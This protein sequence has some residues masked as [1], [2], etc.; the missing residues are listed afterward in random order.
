MYHS[1]YP[2][3][4]RSC[5]FHLSSQ[6]SHR[7]CESSSSNLKALDLERWSAGKVVEALKVAKYTEL[8]GISFRQPYTGRELYAVSTS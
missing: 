5:S 8:A 4:S 7:Y 2:Y 3:H 1:V 6:E